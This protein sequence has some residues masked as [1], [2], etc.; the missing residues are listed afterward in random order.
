MPRSVPCPTCRQAADWD[1]N[2]YR[3][4]CSQRCRL[5]DLGNWTEER[6]RIAGAPVEPTESPDDPDDTLH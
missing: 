6:Y 4:F 2:P 3:P 1:D 5:L